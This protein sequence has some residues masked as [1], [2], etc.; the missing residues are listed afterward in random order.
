MSY[1]PTHLFEIARHLRKTQTQAEKILWQKLRNRRLAG[2][3]FLRQHPIGGYVVD[4]YCHEVR[5]LVELEGSIH[6]LPSQKEYDEERFKN[7][8]SRNLKILRFRNEMVI[9]EIDSVLRRIL[10]CSHGQPTPH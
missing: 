2:L 5:L 7:L 9:Q 3:K 1:K 6:D 8:R 4:F 10:D